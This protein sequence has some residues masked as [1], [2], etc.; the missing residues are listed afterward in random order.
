MNIEIL[1]K[2]GKMAIFASVVI[3]S[4]ITSNVSEAES[5]E[6]IDTDPTQKGKVDLN[7]IKIDT[8][9]MLSQQEQL[10]SQLNEIKN[11]QQRQQQ[12]LSRLNEF[13]TQQQEILSQRNER[14]EKQEQQML[15]QLKD[16]NHDIKEFKTEHEKV[17]W[18]FEDQKHEMEELQT[19]LY[20]S[21]VMRCPC[22][23]SEG[24]SDY[25]DSPNKSNDDISRILN[26]LNNTPNH[27]EYEWI[28][29]MIKMM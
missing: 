3:Y 6:N 4:V 13:I 7:D 27:D 24:N 1:K 12:M 10:L 16:L 19:Q 28:G 25:Y 5:H 9:Q 2:L 26:P 14:Q 20:Y 15:H 23:V 18:K 8:K 17:L 21:T 22:Y 11:Q 29:E